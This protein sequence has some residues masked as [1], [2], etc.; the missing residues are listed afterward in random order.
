MKFPPYSVL[1]SVY[2]KENPRYFNTSIKSMLCQTVKPEQF[3]IVEDGSL[4][5]ELEKV[6]IKYKNKFPELFS[7]VKLEK[8]SGLA[9]ALDCGL[10]ECRNELV[11]RMDSDD[12]SLKNRCEKQ[13]EK[14]MENKTLALLGCNIAEFCDD[15]HVVTSL[16]NVPPDY[17]TI[18]KQI[19]RRDPFNHPTVM[20]KKSEVIR[21]GGYG[22]LRRRQDFDLFSRMINMGC[23]AENINEPLVLFRSNKDNYLRRKS[24]ESCDSYIKVVKLNY[25]RGYCSIL[26]LLYII[27]AEKILQF[28]PMPVMI[29]VSDHLLRKKC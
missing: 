26:D 16:R 9:I 18:C 5:D 19:K 20:F 7:V 4:P 17:K 6:I 1:M 10:K 23:Y 24:K 14:F 3:V 12:I 21:C 2:C 15:P 25:Q 27:I 8:N 13:L 29:F 22:E 11:A 28:M